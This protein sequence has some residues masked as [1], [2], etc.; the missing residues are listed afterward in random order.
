MAKMRR[1]TLLLA[2][3]A[4]AVVLVSSAVVG[5]PALADGPTVRYVAPDGLCGGAKPC[6]AS[7]QAGV[8]GAG[9]GDVIKV[10]GGTYT[11]SGGATEV[12]MI[13]T[14]VTIEEGTRP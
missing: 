6:Y 5:A 7:I 1:L 12:L 2:V 14:P 3:L 8:D 9:L 4:G 11:T 13:S 10:A